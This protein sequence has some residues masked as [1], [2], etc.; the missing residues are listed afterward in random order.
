LSLKALAS[1]ARAKRADMADPRKA[2][3]S[4]GY[5]VGDI[6]PLGQRKRLRTF[7]DASA[8][9][10]D[11]I[12]VNGGRRGLQIALRPADLAAMLGAT[13]ARLRA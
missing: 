7:I 5:V 8:E 2:E 11:D 3:R 4:S 9:A 12:V 1:S 6:S 13:F 10:L